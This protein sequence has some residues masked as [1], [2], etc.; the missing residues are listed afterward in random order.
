V[1]SLSKKAALVCLLLTLW[2]AWDF[3]AHHH[4]NETDAV[5]CSVCMAARTAA[6]QTSSTLLLATTFVVIATV[7]VEP[8]L[9]RQR[10]SIFA[11]SVRP[12][13]AV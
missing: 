13:P 4:S 8:V 5:Q 7:R 3:A 11:L 10:V 9:V 6:P 12:P 1:G 2:S